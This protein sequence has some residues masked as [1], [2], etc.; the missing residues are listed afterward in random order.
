MLL[1]TSAYTEGGQTMFSYFL[2]CQKKIFGQR[3]GH[4][5]M[6]PK[7]AT[8]RGLPD[9]AQFYIHSYVDAID[10]TLLGIGRKFHGIIILFRL[11]TYKM[12][13]LTSVAYLGF[14]IGGG[15]QIFAG[16]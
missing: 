14:H 1:A 9:K 12:S 15:G 10:T 6:P 11:V 16:H 13:W 7:Y 3:G 2:L 4:G 8:D 5:P